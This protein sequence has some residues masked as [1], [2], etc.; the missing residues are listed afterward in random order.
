LL[1][2]LRNLGLKGRLFQGLCLLVG[3]ELLLRDK[4]IEGFARVLGDDGVGLSG[5]ILRKKTG[6]QQL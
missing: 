6:C 2:D 4:L 5:G 1:L 3:I